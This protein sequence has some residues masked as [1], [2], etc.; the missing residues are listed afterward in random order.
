MVETGRQTQRRGLAAAGGADDAEEFARPD[1]EAE[2]LDDGLAA[3]LQRD[4]S[5]A[6]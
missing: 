6:I 5:N 4:P 1:A 2:I 3:E